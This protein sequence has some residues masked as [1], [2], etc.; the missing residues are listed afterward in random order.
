MI[1]NNPEKQ[2]KSNRRLMYSCY[3]HVIFCPKYRRKVLSGIE[4]R[5]K[6]VFDTIALKYN[7]EIIEIEVMPDHVHMIISCDPSF[8][9]MRCVSRLKGNS[10]FQ[11]RSEFPYLVKKLPTLWTRSAFISTVG[12]VS[13]ETVKQYIE[14]QKG[15]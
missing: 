11:I 9:I 5:L 1:I 4:I 3:Y 8:G 10:S 13:L 7:F 2:Y 14:N 15:K 6:E 12:S